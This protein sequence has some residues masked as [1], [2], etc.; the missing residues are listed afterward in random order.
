HST[1]ADQRAN[2]GHGFQCCCPPQSVILILSARC[3]VLHHTRTGPWQRS[4]CW[5]SLAQLYIKWACRYYPP[6][7][8]RT[9]A[10]AWILAILT[11]LV[12]GATN[13]AQSIPT[14]ESVLGHKPG[15]DF[16]LASYDESR[17]Y[18]RKLAASSDRIKLISI[19]RTTRGVDWEI[20]V[21]SSPQNLARL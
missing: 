4:I 19:G 21:I 12:F 9:T 10:P 18:F 3:P 2:R 15:D 6:M 8:N 17:E 16:Y 5:V 13:R 11:M 14:P 20:A 1:K 7:H